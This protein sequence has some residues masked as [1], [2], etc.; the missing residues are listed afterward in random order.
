M[1]DRIDE[2]TLTQRVRDVVQFLRDRVVESDGA[3]GWHNTFQPGRIGTSGTA[4]PLL[5]FSAAQEQP[6]HRSKLLAGLRHPTFDDGERAAWSILSLGGA[7]NVEGTT[8]PM[9]AFIEAG[10]H[11]D[12]GL[13][14]RAREWIIAEQRSGGGWGSTGANIPRVTLTAS[15]VAALRASSPWNPQLESAVVWLRRTQRPQDGSWGATEGESGTVHHTCLA[16]L[17]LLQCNVPRSDPALSRAR[18]F[19]LDAWQPRPQDVQTETYDVHR[20][21][22]YQR[23]VL[24]HDVDALAARTL[25]R[26]GGPGGLARAVHGAQKMFEVPVE[27]LAVEQPS[28][29]NILPRGFLALDLLSLTPTEGAEVVAR[30][31]VAVMIEGSARRPAASLAALTWQRTPLVPKRI[32]PVLFTISAVV[33]L[34]LTAFL[35]FGELDLPSY[36]VGVV[37]PVLLAGYAFA[38]NRR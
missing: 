25:L 31:Q 34:A 14:G 2:P 19:I 36:L 8:W 4:L 24:E 33:I 16:S 22:G 38:S 9:I 13:V 12:A 37:L 3:A 28:L 15:A 5:F 32:E 6:P 23:A 20:D 29:W 1:A 10:D 17:A 26:L 21:D 27:G 35:L 18:A 11:S 30:R 7:P